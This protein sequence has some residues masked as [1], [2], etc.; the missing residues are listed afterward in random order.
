MTRTATRKPAGYILAGT[1]GLVGAL[2]LGRPELAALAAP[3]LLLPAVAFALAPQPSVEALF[4]LERSRA[5][6]NA[7]VRATVEIVSDAELDPLELFFPLPPGL[8]IEGPNPVSV[9]VRPGRPAILDLTIRCERW[10]GYVLGEVYLRAWDQL[11]AFRFETRVEPARP[12]RVYPRDE[13]VRALIRP[14]ETQPLAGNQTA[15]VKGDGIEFADIRPFVVGDRVRRIN[16]RASARRDALWVNE[17]HPERN[18]DVVIFLDAF[19]EMRYGGESSLDPLVRA[20]IAVARRYLGLRDRVGLVSFGGILRWLEPAGGVVQ[21]YRVVEAV[22]D[23]RVALSYAWKDVDVI[24]RRTLPANALV[25]ALTPL[26]DRRSIGALLDLSGRGYDLCVVDVSPVAFAPPPRDDA[27]RLA[28]R[29]W[30]LQRES[31][32]ARFRSL[33]VAAAEWSADAPLAAPMEEVAAFR[34]YAHAPRH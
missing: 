10:G 5:L 34:H 7:A 6:E 33:G 29:V 31:V 28:R 2:A 17:S 20:A 13:S 4:R 21:A 12:L 18:T 16:W 24:P 1:L 23:T 22:L 14:R 3:F 9:S 19:A 11:G 30:A 8:R 27:E 25:V 32:R 26:L 15:R